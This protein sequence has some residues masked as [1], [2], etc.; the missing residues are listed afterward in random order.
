MNL[1]FSENKVLFGVKYVD[2]FQLVI[3]MHRAGTISDDEREYYCNLQPI[4]PRTRVSKF[5]EFTQRL[6]DIAR[7]PKSN[8]VTKFYIALRNTYEESSG[9]DANNHYH[10]ARSLRR[11]GMLN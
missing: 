3:H 5:N 8:I 10:L 4:N 11:T 9:G 7:I 1:F 6:R 2:F